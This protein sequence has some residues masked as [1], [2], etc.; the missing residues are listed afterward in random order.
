MIRKRIRKIIL[1]SLAI[2]VAIT[3]ASFV[4][5]INRRRSVIVDYSKLSE[6]SEITDTIYPANNQ[7]YESNVWMGVYKDS[8][9]FF[10][11]CYTS[12]NRTEY[13]NYL[14]VFQDN[15]IIKL[16]EM[17]NI[18]IIGMANGFFYFFDFE[19]IYENMSARTVE[20]YCLDLNTMEERLLY[21]GEL[22]FYRNTVLF[23]ENGMLYVPFFENGKA[24]RDEVQGYLVICDGVLSGVTEQP[25]YYEYNGKK[26]AV[27]GDFSE[28]LERIIEYDEQ[29]NKR[30][31]SLAPADN[32]G[33]IPTQ[34]GL[35][36]Q[37]EGRNTLCYHIGEN[38]IEPLFNVPCSFSISTC[39]VID[40]YV[41]LSLL[42]YEKIDDETYKGNLRYEN[43]EIEGTYRINLLDHAIE[44]ISDS[45][46]N[47]LFYFGG[48]QLFCC[49]S[50]CNISI[51][52]LQGNTVDTLFQVIIPN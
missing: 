52:D 43:D 10:P 35:V 48:Q 49:D 4:Y 24:Y 5:I 13:D 8:I 16:K 20:I 6:I 28:L 38:G 15:H 9:Y 2:I 51:M 36:I 50:Q 12:M 7:Q 42:R 11:H 19:S 30:E 26:Y 34:Y 47:G 1:I 37:N 44:K 23:S 18:K 14:C 29:N 21:T 41:Y 32:R 27:I 39:T 17:E 22:D 31:V 33:I 45:I 46:Y 25:N 40:N 3:I